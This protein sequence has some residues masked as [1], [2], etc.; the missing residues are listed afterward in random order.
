MKSFKD[1]INDTLTTYQKTI[2][3]TKENKPIFVYRANT[4][5]KTQSKYISQDHPKWFAYHKE[6][7]DKYGDS[8]VYIFNKD[9]DEKIFRTGDGYEKFGH[10]FRIDAPHIVQK[11]KDEG[12]TSAITNGD[13]IVS[14]YPERLVL[15]T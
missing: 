8:Q 14:F 4:P 10:E 5:V 2:R 6:K 1:Y 7:A 12:Y 3:I 11:L 15:K 9:R 13:E